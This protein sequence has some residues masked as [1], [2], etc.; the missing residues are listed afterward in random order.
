MA[1][2]PTALADVPREQ[3]KVCESCQLDFFDELMPT[4]AKAIVS[5]GAN[6]KF[7]LATV[8][9]ELELLSRRCCVS[10]S[11]IYK[12]NWLHDKEEQK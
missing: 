7:R 4:V 5:N 3:L 9:A 6:A 1:Y 10:I 11:I 8:S 2:L 12:L